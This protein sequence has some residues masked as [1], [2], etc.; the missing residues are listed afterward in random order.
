MEYGE[1]RL[2][3]YVSVLAAFAG[4]Q[5]LRL[6]NQAHYAFP[7]S[8]TEKTGFGVE[9]MLGPEETI[10][11]TIDR[12]KETNETDRM[13]CTSIAARFRSVGWIELAN[14]YHEKAK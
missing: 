11:R 12:G 2:K 3:D 6:Y 8:T 5:L 10:L 4:F 14:K 1:P 9:R 13:H 7:E